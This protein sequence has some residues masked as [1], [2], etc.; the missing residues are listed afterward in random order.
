MLEFFFVNAYLLTIGFLCYSA[1][2]P[3]WRELPIWAKIWCFPFVAFY[4][5]DIT[6]RVIFCS[7]IFRD[8]AIAETPTVTELCD[9]WSVRPGDYRYKLARGLC[10]VLNIIQP[11]HCEHYKEA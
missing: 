3:V 9:K 5:V 1:L 6:M 7:F 8:F 2:K 11:K 10:R 4:P